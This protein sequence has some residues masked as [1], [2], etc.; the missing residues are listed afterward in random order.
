VGKTRVSKR[1]NL[2]KKDDISTL[3]VLAEVKFLD[4]LLGEKS[5][6]GTE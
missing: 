4:G 1:Q 6:H 5:I 3:V 2:R